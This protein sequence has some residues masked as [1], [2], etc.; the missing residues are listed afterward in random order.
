MCSHAAGAAV[1]CAMVVNVLIAAVPVQWLL[2][3]VLTP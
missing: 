1:M 3:S 2:L